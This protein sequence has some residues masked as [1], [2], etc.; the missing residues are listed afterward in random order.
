MIESEDGIVIHTKNRYID[1][2][3]ISKGRILENHGKMRNDVNAFLNASQDQK[4]TGEFEY[5]R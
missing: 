5:G 4:L 1:P 2:F 3:V